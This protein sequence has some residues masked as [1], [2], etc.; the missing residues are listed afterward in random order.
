MAACMVPLIKKLP[1]ASHAFGIS[2]SVLQ[3]VFVLRVGEA[4]GVQ[5]A[6]E[7]SAGRV[8]ALYQSMLALS[9]TKGLSRAFAGEL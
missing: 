3:C 2:I 6:Q 9:F 1:E 4:R 8:E 7:K 5:S